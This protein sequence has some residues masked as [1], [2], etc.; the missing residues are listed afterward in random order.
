MFTITNQKTMYTG[1]MQED[2]PDDCLNEESVNEYVKSTE[3]TQMETPY[4][5]I[6][7]TALDALLE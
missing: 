7:E 1:W 5:S 4:V 3:S 6:I 2:F